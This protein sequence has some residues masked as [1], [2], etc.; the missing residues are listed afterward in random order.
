MMNKAGWLWKGKAVSCQQA[1]QL[2]VDQGEAK[3]DSLFL[4]P[5]QRS[6]ERLLV[7]LEAARCE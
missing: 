6:A 3:A 7:L 2:Q 5:A 4:W 1:R